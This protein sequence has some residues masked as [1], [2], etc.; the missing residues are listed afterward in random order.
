MGFM[1]YI[2]K[3]VHIYLPNENISAITIIVKKPLKKQMKHMRKQM[4]VLLVCHNAIKNI[5]IAK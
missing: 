4:V 3:A 5:S 1:K 2:Q